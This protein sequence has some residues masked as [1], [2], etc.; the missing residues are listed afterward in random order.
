MI[1]FAI[2]GP[3]KLELAHDSEISI[4]WSKMARLPNCRHY[5]SYTLLWQDR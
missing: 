3:E 1:G 5:S 4:T 2:E